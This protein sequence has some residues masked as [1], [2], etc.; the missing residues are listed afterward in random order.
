MGGGDVVFI[1][2]VVA[3]IIL[4]LDG[5]RRI[6]KRALALQPAAVEPTQ[7]R[8]A[9]PHEST[10]LPNQTDNQINPPVPALPVAALAHV[11]P[12]QSGSRIG[13]S[14]LIKGKV[15]SGESLAIHGTIEGSVTA[16]EHGV[17]V[18]ASGRVSQSIEARVISVA[19]SVTGRLIATDQAILLASAR[20]NGSVD[21]KRL[22]CE[23]GAWLK[24]AVGAT[25]H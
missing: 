1:L 9:L 8:A 16:K 6:K 3:L 12:T 4:I 17:T 13:P 14:L 18:A 19:G 22:K 21:A 2:S 11:L 25:A 24:V 20:V 5:K 7:D 23:S 15:N 10:R